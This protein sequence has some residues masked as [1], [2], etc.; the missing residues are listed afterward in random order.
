MIVEPRSPR[1]T[2]QEADQNTKGN[3]AK[4]AELSSKLP[5]I[6]MVAV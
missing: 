5:A 1:W 6:E 4:I 2:I 3:T